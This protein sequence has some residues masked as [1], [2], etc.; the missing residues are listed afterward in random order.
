MEDTQSQCWRF[1]CFIAQII[2]MMFA[3]IKT[4]PY[5][6]YNFQVRRISGNSVQ[7]LVKHQDALGLKVS[8]SMSQNNYLQFEH[9]QDINHPELLS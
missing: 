4:L 1:R 2:T 6:T 8:P 5:T 9:E 3:G 7:L